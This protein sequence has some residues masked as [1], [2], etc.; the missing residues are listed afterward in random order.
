VGYI[1]TEV[2]RLDEASGAFHLEDRDFIAADTTKTEGG[3]EYPDWSPSDLDSFTYEWEPTV[4]SLSDGTTDAFALFDPRVYGSD[5]KDTEY[6]VRGTYTFADSGTQVAALLQFD[7]DLTFRGMVCF[8]NP[9]W[10]GAAHE[11]L[12]QAGDT[13]TISEEWYE[14]DGNGGYDITRH[15]G[16]TLTFGDGPLTVTAHD[17]LPGSYAIG[18]EATSV[19]G[20][21]VI[22]YASVD[23]TQ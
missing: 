12:P 14:P 13:F 4:Y 5:S 1:Y 23:V 22:E 16:E 10:T 9:D 2:S 20:D 7:A 17:S 3:V 8:A 15:D 11:D 18:I 6:D 21:D 19:L